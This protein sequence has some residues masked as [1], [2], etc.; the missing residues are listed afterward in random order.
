MTARL[1]ILAACMCAL[2]AY[3]AGCRSVSF[4]NGVTLNVALLNL[5][6]ATA[7]GTG[8]GTNAVENTA[9]G[10]GSLVLPGSVPGAKTTLTVEQP[11]K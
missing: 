4:C 5:R 7:Q 8:G 11:T 6:A 10:N 9:N 3:V 1:V 2:A